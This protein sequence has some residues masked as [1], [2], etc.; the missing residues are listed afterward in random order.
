M[1][2]RLSNH[3][4]A[5]IAL[6]VWLVSAL[7]AIFLL[8]RIDEVVHSEL[9]NYGLR[10]SLDWATSYWTF[11]RLIFVCLA[12][13]MVL[14]GAVL[15][16]SFLRRGY[17]EE[18]H[19]VMLEGKGGNGEVEVVRENHMV[20]S[21]PKCKRVFGRPLVMLDFSDGKTRFVNVCP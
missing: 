14:S 7:F 18:R 11:L 15:V 2:G 6:A 9:Y 1:K 19:V 16:F 12:L 10:F 8:T 20:I 13:P 21:C 17:S 5:R 3:W 4:S